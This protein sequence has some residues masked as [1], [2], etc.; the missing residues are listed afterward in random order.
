MKLMVNSMDS[1]SKAQSK[2]FHSIRLIMLIALIAYLVALSYLN[3]NQE[4][5]VKESKAYK[6]PTISTALIE[7]KLA[8]KNSHSTTTGGPCM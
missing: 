2:F 7:P 4:C 8:T 5:E 6:V 3:L 1:V